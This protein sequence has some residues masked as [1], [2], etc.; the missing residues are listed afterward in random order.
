M[1]DLASENLKREKVCVST[2]M[3]VYRQKNSW[4]KLLTLIS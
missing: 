4:S 1:A 3:I 2:V